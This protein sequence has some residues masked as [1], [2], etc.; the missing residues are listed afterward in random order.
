MD[1]KITLVNRLLERIYIYLTIEVFVILAVFSFIPLSVAKATTAEQLQAIKLEMVQLNKQVKQLKQQRNNPAEQLLSLYLSLEV[2]D[3]FD[4]YNV[5]VVLDNKLVLNK[6]YSDKE[7]NALKQGG[8]QKLYMR[9]IVKA[10]H[11]ISAF[12]L[13]TNKQGKTYKNGAT[14]TFDNRQ[15]SSAIELKVH[16]SPSTE[17]V[18]IAL[19]EL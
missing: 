16:L 11:R 5:K 7:I 2:N 15:T 12:I 8:V 1:I 9:N 14:G 4:L 10:E 17:K 18:E 19:L 3:E 13:G 6:N